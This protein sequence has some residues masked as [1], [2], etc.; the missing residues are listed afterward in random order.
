MYKDRLRHLIWCCVLLTA[1]SEKI[2][3]QANQNLNQLTG[4][5]GA[6]ENNYNVTISQ[7]LS[8]TTQEPSESN[9]RATADTTILAIASDKH[10]NNYTLRLSGE[11]EVTGERNFNL[12]DGTLRVSRPFY[13][14]GEFIMLGRATVLL[15]MSELTREDRQMITSASV[16]TSNIYTPRGVPGLALIYIPNATAFFNRYTMSLSGLSNFKYRIGNT[17]VGSYSYKSWNTTL[18]AAY[19]RSFTYENN[20][21]DIYQFD[22][23]GSYFFN[24]MTSVSLGFSNFG[25]PLAANGQSNIVRV[26]DRNRS[27]IYTNFSYTF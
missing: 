13:R 9:Y 4:Q 1:F 16:S 18:V 2:Y 8:S 20:T 22:V 23:S 25:S 14:R 11:K 10:G 19:L 17:F 15:P 5:A 3:G 12:L 6:D 21:V 7:S 24:G 27:I 26:Y